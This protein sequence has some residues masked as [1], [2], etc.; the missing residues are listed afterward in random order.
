[1]SPSWMIPLTRGWKMGAQYEYIDNDLLEQMIEAELII[2][3]IEITEQV[4]NQMNLQD[5]SNL[6]SVLPEMA[7]ITI[8]DPVLCDV[9]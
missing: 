8:T 1:M 9:S 4:F 3:V 7:S 2:M 6:A 5:Y